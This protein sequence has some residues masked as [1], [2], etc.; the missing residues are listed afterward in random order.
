M[1]GNPLKSKREEL[2]EEY[3]A[4][5]VLHDDWDRGAME[6]TPYSSIELANAE[7]LKRQERLDSNGLDGGH[8]KAYKKLPRIR[9]YRIYGEG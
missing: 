3:S 8:W 7:A 4:F 2:N 6:V 1:S 9:I 5:L